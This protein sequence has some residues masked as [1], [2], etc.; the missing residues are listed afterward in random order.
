LVDQ[1]TQDNCNKRTDLW[2]GSI[3][4]RARFGLEVAKA[5]TNAVG[6]S[7]VGMR[8]SPWSTF[9][10][11]RMED[12]VP[13]FTYLIK[14]LKEIGLAYLHLVESR[15]QGNAEIE[16]S[17]RLDFA[18]DAWDNQ[19]PVFVAGGFTNK[20]A[21]EAAD[22]DYKNRDV[23]IVFG[24]HFI[25]NPDLP[26]RIR[27]D[28]EFQKYNRDT[29]YKARSTEGYTDYPFSKEWESRESRL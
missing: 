7:R 17:D 9:Q 8:L 15:I 3:E 25:S 21:K 29:F 23:A 14:G 28:V 1:F 26:F 5:V 27:E 19:S 6:A 16:S 12:P 4:N 13:Q 24:R 20:S 10:G 11:M 2:G 22:E 18:I